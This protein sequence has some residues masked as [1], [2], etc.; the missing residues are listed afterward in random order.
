MLTENEELIL[1]K[2]TYQQLFKVHIYVSVE[3]NTLYHTV[4][5]KLVITLVF[6]F[7]IIALLS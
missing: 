2:K 4:F 7:F 1:V 3:K 5:K 6:E